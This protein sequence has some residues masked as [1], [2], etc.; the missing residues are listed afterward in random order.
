M[1]F[2]TLMCATK[3]ET[4]QKMGLGIIV[5]CLGQEEQTVDSE[6]RNSVFK[7]TKVTLSV[8]LRLDV[9]HFCI[10][11]TGLHLLFHEQSI[12]LLA[13]LNGHEFEFVL[14]PHWNA[15]ILS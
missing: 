14:D 5:Y 7:C 1:V 4:N 12:V 3:D 6:N 15:C 10:S 8:P 13:C 9:T 11:K 2:Y